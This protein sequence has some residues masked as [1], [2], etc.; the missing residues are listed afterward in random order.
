VA[1]AVAWTRKDDAVFGG[2]TLEVAVVVGVSEV[3]LQHVVVYK[4]EAEFGA[5]FWDACV[6]VWSICNPICAPD[7]SLPAAKW[8][9]II[10]SDNVLPIFAS[11]KVPR[12]I[13]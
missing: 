3:V 4:A 6:S 7:S 12:E 11:A 5:D 8:L 1:Y 10:F 2:D 9:L 13:C